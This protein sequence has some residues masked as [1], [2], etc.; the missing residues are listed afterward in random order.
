MPSFI[1]HWKQQC[2]NVRQKVRVLVWLGRRGKQTTR[3][4]QHVLHEV[5]QQPLVHSDAD[6]TLSPFHSVQLLF[7]V[8]GLPMFPMKMKKLSRSACWDT[9]R[10][11]VSNRFLLRRNAVKIKLCG[12]IRTAYFKIKSSL[13]SM[14]CSLTQWWWLMMILNWRRNDSEWTL[15]KC[16]V[17]QTEICGTGTW[18]AAATRWRASRSKFIWWS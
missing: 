1:H 12:K 9:N 7:L 2:D 14:L 18:S 11:L 15:V 4:T 17:H 6:I 10:L 3:R 16:F 13:W 5:T 8:V